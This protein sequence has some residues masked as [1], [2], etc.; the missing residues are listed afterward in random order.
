MK[1]LYVVNGLGF[2]KRISI[3]GAD[4]RVVEIARRLIR[5]G[6]EIGVL[7]TDSGSK[8]LEREGLNAKYYTISAPFFW[9]AKVE[10]LVIGRALS[11]IFEI[12]KST[13]L[14]I[15]LNSY[16][17]VYTSS[18]FICDTIPAYFYKKKN[19]D[20]KLVA[21]VHH[22]IAVP[23][24]R[25]GSIIINGINYFSQRLSF[26]LL[27]KKADII[28][29][30]QTPEGERIRD[31]FLN[32]GFPEEKLA[33]VNNGIDYEFVSQM[34]ASEKRFDACFVGGLRPS[35]GIFDLIP[36]WKK[37]CQ[38]Y[39]DAKLA[40]IGG[41]T[42]KYTTRLKKKIEKEK[43]SQNIIILG[44]LSGKE[45]FRRIKSSKISILPSYEEGWS[46]A[47][48]EAL[49]CGLSVV[50]YDLPTYE[51]FRE[52]V[53]KVPIGNTEEF[54][55]NIVTLLKD[56]IER[57]KPSERAKLIASQFDWNKSAE[58]EWHILSHVVKEKDQ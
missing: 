12:F 52:G 48:C 23:W 54:S 31:Y 51:I 40:I 4:K 2:A 21:M 49:A 28:L 46:I 15:P 13:R 45:L 57:S 5:Y 18:D 35:K 32:R 37:V 10:R 6:A 30:Y 7:T 8:I 9:W 14:K 24:K 25:I 19:P 55:R 43:L 26:R 44:S 36:I 3:G 38:T 42:R 1:I 53:I 16:D 33:M 39:K 27:Q 22:L 11:Y 41:G 34:P 58:A 47:I 29:V 17:I 50:A 56:K 20:L